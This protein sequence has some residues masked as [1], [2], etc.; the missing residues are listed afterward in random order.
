MKYVGQDKSSR[1]DNMRNNTG[2][3]KTV[4][5]EGGDG[6]EAGLEPGHGSSAIAVV[7]DVF[8]D[9]DR[10]CLCYDGFDATFK[11]FVDYLNT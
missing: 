2:E 11:T 8:D 6:G 9:A 7:A 10:F 5:V 1:I 3:D 4:G